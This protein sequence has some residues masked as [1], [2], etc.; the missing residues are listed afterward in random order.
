VNARQAAQVDRWALE[1]QARQGSACGLCGRPAHVQL[2]EDGDAVVWDLCA[3][4]GEAFQDL[5]DALTPG[6]G[7]YLHV[8]DVEAVLAAI[9]TGNMGRVDTGDLGHLLR[10]GQLTPTEDA[11]VRAELGRRS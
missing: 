4:C 8:I 9:R 3:A 11:V 5:A 10:S 6:S 2:L 7:V 1:D